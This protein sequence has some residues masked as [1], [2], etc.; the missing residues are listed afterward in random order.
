MR[1]Y[2]PA[3]LTL[4]LFVS[5]NVF[6]QDTP[7]KALDSGNEAQ[8]QSLLQEMST[9]SD[10]EK[11]VAGLC[12]LAQLETA[13]GNI[14]QSNTYLQQALEKSPKIDKKKGWAVVISWLQAENARKMNDIAGC[15]K[16]LQAMREHLENASKISPV[17]KGILEYTTSLV[18]TDND[19]ARDAAEAAIEAYNN[20]KFKFERGM[21]YLRLADLEWARDKQRRA[22]NY[23]DDAI[24]DFRTDASK[25]ALR[26]AAQTQ[27]LIARKKLEAEDLKGAKSRITI[28]QKDIE[29]AGNPEDLIREFKELESKIQ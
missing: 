22:F 24:H 18:E 10:A 21:A 4:F 5:P 14:E 8:A 23:Y 17:W 11:A 15:K 27:L 12:G 9:Q 7:Q 2:L 3:L 1:L 19:D 25:A 16:S 13:K 20:T 28:A 6:A 29:A 26:K